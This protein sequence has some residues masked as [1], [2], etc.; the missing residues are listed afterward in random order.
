MKK[1]LI[2]LLVTIGTLSCFSQSED[3][4]LKKDIISIDIGFVGVWINYEKHIK[5]LFTLKSQV[6]LEGGF[7]VGSSVNYFILTPTLRLEPRY[8]YNF[9]RRVNAGKKTSYN[10]SNYLALTMMYI[11][12]LFSISN[13]SGL[14]VEKGFSLIPK[15]GIKR[16]LGQRMNFEFAIGAGPW[17]SESGQKGTVGLDIRYGYNLK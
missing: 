3:T 2:T 11:P 8:Y 13:V 15:F 4:V 9:N 1:S 14:E 12:N 6:G 17:F 7:L 16:T 10:A 5:K